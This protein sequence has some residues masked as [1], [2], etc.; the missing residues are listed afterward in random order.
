MPEKLEEV[1]HTAEMRNVALTFP[2]DTESYQGMM[3][4]TLVDKNKFP[5]GRQV[6]L[7]LP[8]GVQYADKVE[9][10]NAELGSVGGAAADGAGIDD[11][12]ALPT[13]SFKEGSVQKTIMTQIIG[14][15]N[16]RAG[17]IARARNRVT[18]NP[19]TRALFKQVG[20]RSFAFQFKLI[21][22]NEREAES[23]RQIIKLFRTELYP[24]DIPF[25]VGSVDLSYGYKFPNGFTIEQFYDKKQIRTQR[26]DTAFLDSFTTNYNTT[27]QTFFIGKDGKPH[28]S[29]IDIAMTFTESKTL[30][31]Q[32]VKDGY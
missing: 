25:T 14:A 26:I 28:F 18:P 23:I 8:Q 29:E 27:N 19:N 15:A 16:D 9:Y 6:D 4:F 13:E 3:R 21:P 5:L 2:E 17:T 22:V 10:E 1:H 12:Y 31:R 30:T 11:D 24:E 32:S 20:L 7:Y